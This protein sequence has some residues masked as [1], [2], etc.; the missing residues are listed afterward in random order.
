MELENPAVPGGV[1]RILDISNGV[2]DT[3]DVHVPPEA[4]PSRR[5]LCK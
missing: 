1:F 2:S 3:Y 5:N 4:F